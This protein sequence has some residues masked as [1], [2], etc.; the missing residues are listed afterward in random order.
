MECLSTFEAQK[1]K[2]I[3][4]KKNDVPLFRLRAE[5]PIYLHQSLMLNRMYYFCKMLNIKLMSMTLSLI[6]GHF[7]HKFSDNKDS[8]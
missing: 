6:F 5:I 3:S 2:R 8:Y 4:I 1:K 7:G